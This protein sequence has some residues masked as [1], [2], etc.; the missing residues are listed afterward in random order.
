MAKD[1]VT[2][3]DVGGKTSLTPT[4]SSGLTIAEK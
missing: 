4:K 2:D 3:D 1:I